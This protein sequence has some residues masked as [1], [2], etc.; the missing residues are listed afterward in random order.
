MP[1]AVLTVRIT[2][3]ARARLTALAREQGL[4]MSEVVRAAIDAYCAPGAALMPRSSEASSVPSH[5]EWSRP[6][7]PDG[8]DP[9][10][11]L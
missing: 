5:S 9:F 4:T 8:I 10:G 7:A 2:R 6:V 1:K 3:E 11:E